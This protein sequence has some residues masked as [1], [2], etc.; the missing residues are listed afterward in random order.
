MLD[1]ILFEKFR[2]TITRFI[3][4]GKKKMSKMN[5]R[6]GIVVLLDDDVVGEEEG[7]PP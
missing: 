7:P 2:G 4:K 6:Q 1:L 3:Y 5:D